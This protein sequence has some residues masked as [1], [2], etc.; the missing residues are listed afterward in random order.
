[1]AKVSQ[2]YNDITRF[3]LVDAVQK[4]IGEKSFAFVTDAVRAASEHLAVDEVR[5][6]KMDYMD[7]TGNMFASMGFLVSRYDR[8][9]HKML[10]SRPYA[11]IASRGKR[12]TRQALSFGEF[13]DLPKYYSG[14]PNDDPKMR[15]WGR[16]RFADNGSVSG[17]QERQQFI[18]DLTSKSC[19]KS[20]DFWTVY[21]FVAM[22]YARF[23]EYKHGF[24]KGAGY[25]R[26]MAEIVRGEMVAN[27][28]IR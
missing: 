17:V 18:Q 2:K 10:Q 1:M 15:A 3:N 25:A 14:E 28:K 24:S 7:V 6:V 13:Y 26:I 22:P 4:R 20:T 9:R 8:K 11:P 5:K 23:V 27:S 12:P 19:G 16:T 21:C